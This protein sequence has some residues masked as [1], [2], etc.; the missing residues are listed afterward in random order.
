MRPRAR[1][2]TLAASA[3]LAACA[4]VPAAAAASTATVS[5]GELVYTAVSGETNAVTI[6]RNGDGSHTIVDTGATITGCGTAGSTVTCSGAVARI[7][8]DVGDM[9]DSVTIASPLPA[10]VTGGTGGDILTGGGGADLLDGGAG[11]DTLNGGAG[12]DFLDGGD[13]AD[14]L[15]G[16]AGDDFLSGGDGGD[17]TLS[18]GDGNDVLSGGAGHDGLTGGNGNDRLTGGSGPDSMAGGTGFDRIDYSERTTGIQVDLDGNPDD[19]DASD[20]PAGARDAVGADVEEITGGA[21][22][23]TITGDGDAE[24]LIG[25]AGAD[26][27]NGA[28]GADSLSGGDGSDHLTGGDGDDRL[29]DEGS[30]F[31]GPTQDVL[32]GGPG[33]DELAAGA[34]DDQLT[35]G[36][37]TDTLSGAAGDDTLDG[38]PGDDFLAGGGDA[39]DVTGGD[40][41]D[42]ASYLD[43]FA[44]VQADL[45]G[46][47]ADDGGTEDG[48]GDTLHADIEDLTGGPGDDQLTGNGLD[49]RINGGGGDDQLTGLAGNDTLDAGAGFG[50]PSTALE[51]LTGGDD[52]DLLIGRAGPDE[53]QGGPGVDTVDYSDHI[54]FTA[55]GVQ[56]DL[57]AQTRDDGNSIDGAA[58]SRDTVAGVEN[59]TGTL[60]DDTLTGDGQPNAIDGAGGD[61]T[62]TGGA[63]ADL[64]KGD[65]GD[66]TIA[67]RDGVVDRVDCGDGTGDHLTSDRLDSVLPGCETLDRSAT[68]TGPSSLARSGGAAAADLS[69][70]RIE[71]SVRGR[72]LR[73]LLRRGLQVRLRCWEPCVLR[74]RLAGAGGVRT[75]PGPGRTAVTLRPRRRAAALLRR[76]QPS[77]LTLRIR[78]TDASANTRLIRRKVRL[79]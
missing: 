61:D 73:A 13:L 76:H 31:S 2:A 6:T 69:P 28:G 51:T 12:S 20:G 36:D 39:D 65:F 50:P 19:G 4:L 53:M 47:V 68:A 52:D 32:D 38:G 3:A 23:D 49:N 54:D 29:T 78:A 70:P 44:S 22:G 66:D 71:A 21:G 26:T 45:D 46:A 17:A 56:V 62:I 60:N 35:G 11:G 59:I 77:R 33:N 63:G 58:G 9:G 55:G 64:L 34:D 42:V 43:H 40:G 5:N 15:T 75:L 7:D 10:S 8:V 18:G 48:S 25:G 67:A 79:R 16:G 41:R 1:L 24:T 37:G 30:E 74:L 14:S 72:S 57:D 27:L